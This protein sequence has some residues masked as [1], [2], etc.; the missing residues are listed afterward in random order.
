MR[1][2][3]IFIRILVFTAI[4]GMSYAQTRWSLQ[5]NPISP[6]NTNDLG[7]VQFVSS[8]E[9]WIS[10]PNGIL[11]HTSDA[12][13]TWNEVIPFPNDTVSSMSDPAITMWWVN[14]THGWKMNWLG[15]NFSDAH[16][17]VIHRTTDGGVSWTKKILS[18]TPGDIGFQL[19]F[20]DE[21]NGWVL[22]Y[23]FS[24]GNAQFLRTTDGGDNWNQFIGAGIFYFVDVNNGWAFTGT[25]PQGANPPYNIYHTTNSGTDWTKQFADGIGGGYNAIQ[26]TDL[27]N[28]WIVGDS[29]KILKTT[30]GGN[31]WIRITNTGIDP[32]SRSKCIFFLNENTGWIGT[33]DGKIDDN[34]ERVL[35]HTTNGGANWTKEYPP[36]SNGIFSIYFWNENNGYFTAGNCVQNCDGPDSLKIWQGVIGHTNNGGLAS[37]EA[38]NNSIPSRYSLFQNYPNPFNPSTKI[39]YSIPQ[40][41]FVTLKIYDILGNEVS[42]LVNEERSSGSYEIEFNASSLSSGVY[43]YRMQAGNY[44][45]AKRF[46][47]MK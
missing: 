7:K 26:F 35:L 13:M 18:T 41:D 4:M 42:T 23:N 19:Q 3:K 32:K 9:G 16:G 31:N 6:S 17:A 1:H 39:S 15:T 27:K 36:V 5:N 21:N 47:L 8:T 38:I 2:S 14:Q 22:I 12:G 20:V 34:P 25:G 37:V 10:A 45:S 29:S 11:L 46:V 40:A 33:N 24:T 43:F 44:T 30:D 28:G